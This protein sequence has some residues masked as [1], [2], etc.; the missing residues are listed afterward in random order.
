MIPILT[1]TFGRRGAV[2][3]M[4]HGNI[5]VLES[6]SDVCLPIGWNVTARYAPWAE[7]RFAADYSLKYNDS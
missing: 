4:A 2:T 7:L 1:I 3:E 5:T 6:G